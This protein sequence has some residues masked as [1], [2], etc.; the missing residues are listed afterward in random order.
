M[1]HKIDTTNGAA[2]YSLKEI[3]WHGLGQIT[4]DARTSE[5]VIK[6]AK[7]DYIVKKAPVFASYVPEGC[8][9]EA[10][11]DRTEYAIVDKNRNPVGIIPR[12][13][14]IVPNAYVTYRE[15]VH[16]LLMSGRVVT[17][18]YQI[19]QNYEAFDWFD[20]LVDSQNITFETAGA[21]GNGET[22]FISA[23]LPNSYRIVGD[24]SPI[25]QYL[26]LSNT[27]DGSANIQIMFTPIRVVCNNTLSMALQG[28]SN[29]YKIRHTKTAKEKM[30]MAMAALN[31]YNIYASHHVDFL[32]H[33]ATQK[34]EK[35]GLMDY[36]FPM[37]FNPA[38][39]A[40]I[41][42]NNN[43]YIGINEISTKK[44]NK[45]SAMV[46]SIRNG[47]G[48]NTNVGTKYW[49]MNGVTSYYQNTKVYN[50]DEDK[51]TSITKGEGAKMLEQLVQS[52]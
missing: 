41:K 3:P 44:Q 49:L 31:A 34:V 2:M 48:Q 6:L 13:G 42:L 10:V 43:E 22:I 30:N 38:E 27:H 18:T 32:N 52:F 39:M 50:T 21:L 7:L 25:D 12:K 9:A 47:I 35:E 16:K 46:S 8:R 14:E 17:G 51:F 26:L 15:D 20:S 40:L 23:K 11:R 36:I 1:A 19:I 45:V 5:E 33:L 24:D 4:Q 29:K 37:M 28:A